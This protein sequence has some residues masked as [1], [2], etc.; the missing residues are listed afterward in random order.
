MPDGLCHSELSCEC[1]LNSNSIPVLV[2]HWYEVAN[3]EVELKQI[4]MAKM[5]NSPILY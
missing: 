3:E 5:Y 1:F 4:L 2:L